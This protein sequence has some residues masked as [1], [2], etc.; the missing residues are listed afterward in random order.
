MLLRLPLFAAFVAAAAAS[1]LAELG[2][3]GRTG[4]LHPDEGAGL[5]YWILIRPPLK[6]FFCGQERQTIEHTPFNH[7]CRAS[8]FIR[9]MLLPEGLQRWAKLPRAASLL[10]SAD[11]CYPCCSPVPCPP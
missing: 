1:P 11:R 4:F 5:F 2:L 3:S 7:L 6:H 8:E 10:A 9:G